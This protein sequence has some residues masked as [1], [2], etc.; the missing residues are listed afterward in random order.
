M[1]E[2][3]VETVK[4]RKKIETECGFW[5]YLIQWKASNVS[6]DFQMKIPIIHSLLDWKKTN[7]LIFI[8][9]KLICCSILIQFIEM[10]LLLVQ[11]CL[12]LLC[13][14]YDVLMK[15]DICTDNQYY[16]AMAWYSIC[17]AYILQYRRNHQTKF[18]SET[19]WT[20]TPNVCITYIFQMSRKPS[21]VQHPVIF[22]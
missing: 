22:K 13:S 5:Y 19:E 2:K 17:R 9:N 7:F 15:T 14:L 3:F 10:H 18:S 16:M 4:E 20:K 21:N 6:I 11:F 1:T 8:T 12:L